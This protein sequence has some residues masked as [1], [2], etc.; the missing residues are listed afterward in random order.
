M[1]DLTEP[2]DGCVVVSEEDEPTT[3]VVDRFLTASGLS[4]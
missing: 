2:L 4:S 3:I 1:Q